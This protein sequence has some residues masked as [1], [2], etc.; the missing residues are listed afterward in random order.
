MF[1]N[2]IALYRYYKQ[3]I[4]VLLIETPDYRQFQDVPYSIYKDPEVLDEKT[5]NI[6]NLLCIQKKLINCVLRSKSGKDF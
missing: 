4:Q 2:R 5:K 1:M 6:M 3:A